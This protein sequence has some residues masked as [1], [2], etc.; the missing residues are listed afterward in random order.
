MNK[1]DSASLSI[2]DLAERTGIEPNTIAGRSSELVK[3]DWA[4]RLDKARYEINPFS[5]NPILDDIAGSKRKSDFLEPVETRIPEKNA[6][7]G[8]EQSFPAVPKGNRLT[9]SI[10]HL[11]ET[12]WGKNPRDWKDINE[13]LKRNALH[14]SK[15][16]ITGTLT[17][18]TQSGKIRRIKEGH[19]YKYLLR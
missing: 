18:M 7:P 12:E 11:L 5:L 17:L 3:A 13:A 8:D 14:Y 9:D 16:S 6:E 4:R 2:S 1:V 10:L 15:G 19:S